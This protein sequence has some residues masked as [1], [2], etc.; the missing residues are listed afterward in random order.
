MKQLIKSGVL[1]IL[2]MLL[3]ACTEAQEKKEGVS[4]ISSEELSKLQSS[5]VKVVDVRTLGEV[6][7][8]KIPGAIHIE[9]SA[10]L[11]TKMASFDKEQ[12]VIVYCQ[13]GGRS[14][15]A[16]EQLKTAGFKTIYN[17]GGG[18]ADW[19]SKGNKVE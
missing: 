6:Q 2:A 16:A 4:V 7:Q 5:G 18:M 8:G 13:A 15:K 3:F 1:A 10:D 9:I 19:R 12:P 11:A 17:Y 14:A